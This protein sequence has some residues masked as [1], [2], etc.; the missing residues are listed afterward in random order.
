MNAFLRQNPDIKASYEGEERIVDDDWRKEFSELENLVARGE[1]LVNEEF[2]AVTLRNYSTYIRKLKETYSEGEY[3]PSEPTSI[4]II[5]R[6]LSDSVEAYRNYTHRPLQMGTNK[7]L[8]AGDHIT[9]RGVR[10]L[11]KTHGLSGEIMS[12]E[13]LVEDEGIQKISMRIN[14]RRVNSQVLHRL[15]PDFYQNVPSRAFRI[16]RIGK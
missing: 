14:L 11:I 7:Y 12:E 15:A 5:Q 4:K 2:D 6:L 9:P 3:F 1:K 16:G 10:L 8:A 13:E